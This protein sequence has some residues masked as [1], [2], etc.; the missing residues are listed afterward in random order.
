[1]I[2]TCGLTVGQLGT[3]EPSATQTPSTPRSAPVGSGRVPGR[4]GAGRRRAGRM[5]GGEVH[6]ADVERCEPLLELGLR[7]SGRR[8]AAELDLDRAGGEQHAA[9]VPG[10]GDDPAAVAAR[11]PVDEHRAGGAEDGAG[12]LVGD[13][14]AE[15]RKV[16]GAGEAAE[17]LRANPRQDHRPHARRRRGR[18]Q[19]DPVALVE[20]LHPGALQDPVPGDDRLLEAAG[21]PKRRVDRHAA[22]ESR[23]RA[24]AAATQQGGRLRRAA[25]DDHALGAQLEPGAVDAAAGDAPDAPALDDQPLHPDAGSDPRARLTGLRERVQVDA[26]LGVVGAA[27]RTLA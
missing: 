25:G 15:G 3:I 24:Q 14:R 5:E 6:A 4:I 1:M 16:L 26:R 19:Q 27:D 21:N 13:H 10:R 20:R 2:E 12:G 8:P 9:C 22:T 18:L 7:A 11:E 17:Q 23:M